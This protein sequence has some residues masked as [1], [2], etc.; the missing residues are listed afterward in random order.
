MGQEGLKGKR[1]KKEEGEMGGVHRDGLIRKEIKLEVE[2]E[3]GRDHA[4]VVRRELL[5]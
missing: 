1:G 5:T 3:S 4:V 2:L